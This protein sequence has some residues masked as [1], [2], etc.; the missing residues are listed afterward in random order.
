MAQNLKKIKCCAECKRYAKNWCP[1]KGQ[2]THPERQA[3]SWAKPR[4][5]RH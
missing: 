4:P 2:I 1:V 5:K 3:C